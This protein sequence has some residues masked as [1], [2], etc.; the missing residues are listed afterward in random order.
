[1]KNKI[2]R[3]LYADDNYLDVELLSLAFEELKLEYQL[4]IVKN[5]QEA[6]DYLLYQGIFAERPRETPAAI[7]LDIKMPK[8]D[9]IEVLKGLRSHSALNK[10]P[11]FMLTSSELQNDVEICYQLGANAYVVKP[12]DFDNFLIMIKQ[13]SL[14]WSRLDN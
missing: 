9:G 8:L 14:F 10:V 4:D 11:V 1:M 13:M 12:I 6:L 3:V 7:L 2:P 5:G